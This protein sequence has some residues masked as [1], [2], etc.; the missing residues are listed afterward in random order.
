MQGTVRT[1]TGMQGTVRT[2]TGK[3]GTNRT[4]NRHA[5]SS[6]NKKQ[7]CREQIELEKDIQG[8]GNRQA[9]EKS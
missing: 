7:A 1:R 6:Y 9:G 3:E 5:G 4:R 8:I 2:R